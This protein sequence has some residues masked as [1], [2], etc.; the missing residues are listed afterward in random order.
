MELIDFI[1]KPEFT[2]RD[3]EGLFLVTDDVLL[4]NAQIYEEEKLWRIQGQV[5]K[6]QVETAVIVYDTLDRLQEQ[7]DDTTESAEVRTLAKAVYKALSKLYEYEFYINLGDQTVSQM[8]NN[9]KALGVLIE[10]EIEAITAAATYRTKPF[11][12]VTIDQIRALRYPSYYDP[13]TAS[14]EGG[15]IVSPEGDLMSIGNG[16]GF[17]FILTTRKA[18]TGNVNI[19]VLA[20]KADESVFTVQD[21]FPIN[22]SK[23]W[24]ANTA[25][26]HVFK[27]QAGLV[28]YRYFKF[29]YKPPFSGAFEQVKVE[30]V[31]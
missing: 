4:A 30:R 26:A 2:E 10:P 13:V 18:F 27:R 15:Q 19:R 25:Y 29:M 3:E 22:I 12:K 1:N 20:R 14:A 8:F 11:E 31:A 9:A 21:S 6:T 16:D 28:G 24:E 7:F 17:R 5:R 23:E